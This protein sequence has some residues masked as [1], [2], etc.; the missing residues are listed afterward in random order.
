MGCLWCFT[1][2]VKEH[3]LGCCGSFWYVR[4]IVFH[5]L[6]EVGTDSLFLVLQ[7]KLKLEEHWDWIGPL[8]TLLCIAKE[9]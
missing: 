9:K 7:H 4:V 6:E 1:V 3:K 2:V 8:E 5:L